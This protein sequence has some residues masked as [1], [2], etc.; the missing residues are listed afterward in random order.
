MGS[1]VCQILGRHPHSTYYF[2]SGDDVDYAAFVVEVD[3]DLSALI[4][5]LEF[6]VVVDEFDVVFEWD[7]LTVDEQ[8]Q[9][10]SP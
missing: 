5:E 2:T 1:V 4:L 8:L 3:V 9:G 10:A 7:E 6:P